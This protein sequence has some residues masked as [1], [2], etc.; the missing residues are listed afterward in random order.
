[1]RDG[2]RDVSTDYCSVPI[3]VLK[4]EGRFGNDVEIKNL[5]RLTG[6]AG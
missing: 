4:V 1:M 2:K 5:L 3:G 6:H